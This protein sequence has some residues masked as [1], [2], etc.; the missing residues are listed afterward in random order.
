MTS[1]DPN[2]HLG[3]KKVETNSVE[4]GRKAFGGEEPDLQKGDRRSPECGN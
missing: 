2:T 3:K 4:R 1:V